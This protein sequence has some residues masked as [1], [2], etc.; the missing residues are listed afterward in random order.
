MSRKHLV[1]AALAAGVGLGTGCMSSPC[2]NS[3]DR[4]GL[5]SRLGIN[6]R[7]NAEVCSQPVMDGPMLEDC[8]PPCPPPCNGSAG[9]NGMLVPQPGLPPLGPPPRLVPR[10]QAPDMPYAPQNGSGY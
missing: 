6:G 10:P 2:G 4:P 5:F 3:C 9:M 7:R 1:A 8:G